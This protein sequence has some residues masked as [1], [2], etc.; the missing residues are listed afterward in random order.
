[1]NF[2][3]DLI[4]WYKE[5]ERS[6]PWRLTKDPYRIW[7]SEIILQQTR[8]D[9]GLMY[10]K[11]FLQHFPSVKH[12]AEASEDEVLMCWQGLGYY[13]RARN[14]HFSAK[15]IVNE[16]KGVFPEN[17]E[18]LLN[19][20]GVGT[21]TAAA[22]SSICY[23]EHRTVVD[24]NVFR[25]LTRLFGI[26]TPINTGNGKKEIKEL[27]HS[28]NTGEQNGIFNQALMEF[29]ALQCKPKQVDC[30]SCVFKDS[31][32]AYINN[33]V[34]ILPK[35]EKKNIVKNRYLNFF[36]IKDGNND[37]LIKRRE[38]K[39]IWKG[40]FEFPMIET[41]KHCESSELMLSQE[42]VQFLN[43]GETVVKGI[44]EITHLLTHRKLFIRIMELKVDKHN[45]IDD[46]LQVNNKELV[47]Y[48]F[49]KP[50]QAYIEEI[51]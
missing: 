13:S 14:M 42:F 32:F 50:L 2:S 26:E 46:Y 44:K 5:N 11:R 43:G 19:L 21:Y 24:G 17:Y 9:Q 49:P 12:L 23:N 20:K 8:V 41:N 36:Y 7:V 40:L 45:N 33:R 35:K 48:A 10:Y 1:M 16:L 47:N 22:I 15:Y 28:L 4:L 3:S 37:V 25:V 51:K 18:S 31:C 30:L 34:D 27:A 29:G 39:D 6:L 38:K